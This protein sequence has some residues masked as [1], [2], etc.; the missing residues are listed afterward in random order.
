[1]KNLILILLVSL[2]PGFGEPAA[3]NLINSSFVSAEPK[4]MAYND[5]S[6]PMPNW[7]ENW[8]QK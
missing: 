2:Y 6:Y 5:T 4:L 8:Q 7:K 1:M 3:Q